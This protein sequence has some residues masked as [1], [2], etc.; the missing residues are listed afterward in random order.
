MPFWKYCLRSSF[1]SN[2]L[3]RRR[4]RQCAKKNDMRI[5]MRAI[6]QT[7]LLNVSLSIGMKSPVV[8]PRSVPL[9]AQQGLQTALRY[10][11]SAP[12]NDP[13]EA[14]HGDGKIHRAAY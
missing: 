9:L 13:P 3:V 4:R 6:P 11:R 10:A 2:R 14:A 7:M 12:E 5:P 1:I 8:L